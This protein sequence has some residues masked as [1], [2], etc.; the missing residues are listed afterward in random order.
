MSEVK[1]ITEDEFYEQFETVENHLD[2]NASYSGCM[3]ETYG[4]ELDY[5]FELSKKE[6]RVWTIVETDSDERFYITGFHRVNRIGFLVTTEPYTEE[7]EVA[8]EL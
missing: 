7:M 2:E 5:V 8:E 4:E 6:K 1:K 3:F